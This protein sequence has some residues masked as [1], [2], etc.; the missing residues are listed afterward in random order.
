MTAHSLPTYHSQLVDIVCAAAD[1]DARRVGFL[2]RRSKLTGSVFVLTLVCAFWTQASRSLASYARVAESL[3][4]G[5]EISPQS[6]ADRFTPSAVA[7]VKSVL[8]AALRLRLEVSLRVAPVLD[9]FSAVYIIDSTTIALPDALKT[10]YRG[11]GGSASAAAVKCFWLLEW[12]TGTTQQILLDD[13][14]KADQNMGKPLLSATKPGALWLFDL[15]FW[16]L[17]FLASISAGRSF[18]VSRLQ[19]DVT[20]RTP[21]G[22]AIDL[23]AWLRTDVGVLCERRVRLGVNERLDVRLVAERV[24]EAVAAERRR[25][26]LRA[27]QKRGSMPR[28]ETLERL[29]W[30]LWVTNVS[31]QMLTAR[32]VAEVYRIRWQVELLFKTAKSDARITHAT[33]Q[34]THRVECELYAGLIALVIAGQLG[35]LARAHLSALSP[36]KLWRALREKVADWLRALLH[37]ESEGTLCELVDWIVRHAKPTKRKA[38]PSTRDTIYNLLPQPQLAAA[39]TP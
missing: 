35:V 4:P 37:E 22:E 3:E 31:E 26:R 38:K 29:G 9:P 36:V 8:A 28:R 33:S 21:S 14:R 25:K 23:M 34:K 30:S 18:F 2:K 15:G 13:G 24:P 7:L 32:Q 19:T 17:S 1:L 39:Q 5:L 12:L 27:G 20:V 11:V 6:L 16:S 10:L